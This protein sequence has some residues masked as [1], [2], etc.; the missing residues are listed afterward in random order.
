MDRGSEGSYSQC[1][2]PC[3]RIDLES[4][5]LCLGSN[6]GVGA[7]TNDVLIPARDPGSFDR[8]ADSLSV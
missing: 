5:Q 4:G 7:L 6:I 8:Y 2:R 1:V 3:H